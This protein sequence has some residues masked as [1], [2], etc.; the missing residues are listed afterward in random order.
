MILRKELSIQGFWN[1]EYQRGQGDD[2]GPA[3]DFIGKS[4][5]LMKLITHRIQLE[6]LPA[7]LGRMHAIKQE[8]IPH[9]VLKVIVEMS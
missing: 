7:M 8:H 2:W 1:S 9:D 6:E 3:L 5:W 4:P